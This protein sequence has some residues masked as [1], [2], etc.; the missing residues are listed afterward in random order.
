MDSP[1]AASITRETLLLVVGPDSR[2]GS[3]AGNAL[4]DG[5]RR[6]CDDSLLGALSGL[7][8]QKITID[9]LKFSRWRDSETRSLGMGR[10]HPTSI[11]LF[12]AGLQLTWT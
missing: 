9:G 2:G 5:S 10:A 8:E 4:T 12:P 6:C 1:L 11:Q 7:R 3:K